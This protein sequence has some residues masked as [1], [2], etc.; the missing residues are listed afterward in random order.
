MCQVKRCKN[1]NFDLFSSWKPRIYIR[2]SYE[3]ILKYFYKSYWVYYSEK[4]VVVAEAE[5][6][7]II[8]YTNMVIEKHD[9]K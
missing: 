7:Q 1:K 4:D 8:L 2:K 9:K 5:M 6:V 3:S